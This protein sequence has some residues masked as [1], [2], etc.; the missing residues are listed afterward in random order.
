M[1]PLTEQPQR[2]LNFRKYENYE[3]CSRKTYFN[4][5]QAIKNFIN[6]AALCAANYRFFSFH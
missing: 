6:D 4:P 2:A 5:K 1:L 3:K